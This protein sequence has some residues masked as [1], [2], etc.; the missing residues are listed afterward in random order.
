VPQDPQGMTSWD[1]AN[2]AIRAA[3]SDEKLPE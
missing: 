1:V 2:D 3:I